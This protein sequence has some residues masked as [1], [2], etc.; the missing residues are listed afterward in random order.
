MGTGILKSSG[1]KKQKDRYLLLF[2]V[3]FIGMMLAF[4]PT[5]IRNKGIFL[6]YGDFNSQQMMFYQHA[7]EMVRNGNFGW[8]WG[9]DLGSNFI[10][11][12]SFYLLGSPFF[13]LTTLFPL[14]A[15]KYLMPWMLALKT[16]V[17][18]VTSYAYIRR[19]VN[20]PDSCFVGAM[21]YAF[22]GF[23][24][25]NVFFNHFHDVTAFFPLLLLS[26][27]LLTQENKRGFFALCVALC[28]SISY[29]FF[30]CEVV[31]VVIYFFIRCL[32]K[33][34]KM[35]FKIFGLLCFEAVLGVAISCII[36]LPACYDVINNPRVSQRLYGIDMVFYGENVRIPRI[37]QAFFM[38]SDMPA[39]VNILSSDSARWAS[40]AGYLP[41]FSMCGVIAFIRDKKKHWATTLI[42]VSGIM[43]CVPWLN[44]LFV[45]LNSSYYARWFYMPI[46]IM[47]LMTAKVLEE[48]P[49]K[50]KKGF[51]IVAAVCAFFL[52][53][54]MLPQN[55]DGKVVNFFQQLPKK[56]DGE[57]T[58]PEITSYPEMYWMQLAITVILT[59]IL[60]IIVYRL[61]RTK[62]FGKIVAA[63][64][65]AC[66]I[67]T[68]FAGVNFGAVQDGGHEAYIE[69]AINGKDNLDMDKLESMSDI[70]DLYEDNTFYRIDTSENVDNWCMYWGLSS[71]RTFHSVV[72]PSIMNFYET[73][74]QTRDVASRMDPKLYALRGMFSVRY[75]FKRANGQVNHPTNVQGLSGFKYVDTQNDFHIYENQYWIPMGQVYDYYTTD[76]AIQEAQSLKR[77][78]MLLDAVVLN[79]E[80]INKY[81]D[82]LEPYS[83]NV[84]TEDR[85]YE[86]CEEKRSQC[87]YYFKES[88]DGFDA[89]IKL[90][91]EKLVFFSVPYEDGWTATVNGKPVEIENVSYGFMAIR[92][93]EGDNVIRFDYETAGLKTGKIITASGLTVLALYLAASFVYSKKKKPAA[94]TSE[95][96]E[97]ADNDTKTAET[98]ETVETSENVENSVESVD[99]SEDTG[100]KGGEE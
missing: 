74:G 37:I 71:M 57:F 46:L 23:Q 26:F 84:Q 39:R 78:N 40:I 30:A 42:A 75:Y 50:L 93:P 95:S 55:K 17:A 15:V 77:P 70:N 91:E 83:S 45:L 99:K 62:S 36:L 24:L 96:E 67:I 49:D 65:S 66:C 59:A 63:V 43:M 98:I 76:H 92:C 16:S 5:M 6:Y 29:F 54:P 58:F 14:S 35:D 20:N 19:F 89:K 51:I 8:D 2:A 86:T 61:P 69:H 21:L 7:N 94:V 10:G 9:T 90:D 11:S 53:I 64:T 85:Y 27:E 34:F 31:F 22:S 47:C 48:D 33:S 81:A 25:Y 88:S 60:G 12:Y 79:T 1:E 72:P 13:W 38:M 52:A 3:S 87:C 73:I 32:D 56:V 28:A 80:Q 97:K 41:M 44:S 4:L 68:M 100:D 82:I 18:A